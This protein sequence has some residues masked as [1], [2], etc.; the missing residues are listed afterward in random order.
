[1][2]AEED[3]P[4]PVPI[5]K[6]ILDIGV[7]HQVYLERL[8]AQLTREAWASLEEFEQNVTGWLS[9]HT[10]DLAEM[11]HA[12]AQKLIAEARKIQLESLTQAVSD[13]VNKFAEVADYEAEFSA[14]VLEKITKDVVIKSL[15]AGEAYQAALEQ[16]IPATGQLLEDFI[17]HWSQSEVDAV[18]NLVSKGYAQGWTN[19]QIKQAVQGTKA[20]NYTDGI[21][22]RAETNVE[23]VVHTSIQ[24]IAQT[25]RAETWAQNADVI[26]WVRV[27]ATLDSHTTPL[28]RSLD[29]RRYPLGKEPRFPAHVRCRTTT[30]PEVADEFAFLDEGSTRS[31]EFGPVSAKLTYYDWLETQDAEFQDEVLGQKRGQLFRDGGL[32]ANEFA[33][34]NLGRNF[35]P[36]TLDEMRKKEPAAFKKAGL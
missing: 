12:K 31:A 30:V 29:G 24:H 25:A 26:K 17:A 34:L 23:A 32:S 13:V 28:C 35:E 16:P 6:T 21:I 1:M 10:R 36:L 20:A 4:E 11:T 15:K 7:R 27:L 22:A 14:K 3:I 19:Q 33:R 9:S 5:G 8:K 18:G 2:A